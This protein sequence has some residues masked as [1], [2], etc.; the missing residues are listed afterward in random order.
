MRE[1]DLLTPVIDKYPSQ[2][3]NR[4]RG[5]LRSVVA[6]ASVA[7]AAGVLPATPASAADLASIR[8]KVTSLQ[9]EATSIAEQA[10][11]AQVEMNTLQS[12]LNSL[13]GQTSAQQANLKKVQSTMGA[14][15]REQYMNLGLGAGIQLMF[16]TDPKLYLSQA[17]TLE[18]LTTKKANNVRQLTV[19]KQRLQ[20]SSLVVNDQL[21]Q[22]KRTRIRNWLKQNLS[23]PS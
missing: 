5:H 12:R 20:A 23:S 21:A 10:Q 11:Q 3:L 6:L 8:A 22:L 17:G 16:S 14:I 4:S 15:A 2:M 18:I 7:L 9:Q 19:A 13:Q 1:L